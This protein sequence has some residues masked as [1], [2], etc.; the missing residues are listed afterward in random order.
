M[1]LPFRNFP[2]ELKIGRFYL[3][4]IA[5]TNW[6]TTLKL[7][8]GQVTIN[9]LQL[10]LNGAPIQGSVDVNVGVPGYEY[11]VNLSGDKIPIEPIANSFVPDKRGMYKGDLLL[12]AQIKGKGTTGANL[13]K[14]L[15]GLL[16][17]TLTNANIQIVSPKLRQFLQPVATLLGIPE[18]LDSPL[19]WVDLHSEIGSGRIDFKDLDLV[20]PM[21]RLESGGVMPISEVLTNSPFQNWPVNLY[22]SR[23][24]AEKARLAPAGTTEAY[25]KLPS[26]LRVAGTLGNPK[27]QIDKTA[28]AGTLLEKY[29]SKIPGVNEATGGLLQGI[30]GILSGGRNASTN[31]PPNSTTNQPPSTNKSSP[32]KLFDLLK[33]PG[34]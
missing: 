5:I 28:L 10:T 22:L 13:Q 26:F 33:K 29:G 12:N 32:L 3:R 27:A 17:F 18:L 8:S 20:S 6:L 19:N 23:S 25:V 4:E 30:G 31:Q 24:L 21:F 7:D 34:K 11:N 2:V 9:P 1:N 15:G 14:N 16:G